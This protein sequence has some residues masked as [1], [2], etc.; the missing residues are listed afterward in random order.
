MAINYSKL[1]SLTAREVIW[2]LLADGFVLKSQR[3]SYRRYYHADSRRVTVPYH[4]SGGTFVPKT[5]R[6]IIEE[7]AQWT[8]DDL[9][10]LDLIR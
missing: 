1:R 7:Q 5:L 10:R 2:A 3:G 9:K 8:E 4:S 6:S